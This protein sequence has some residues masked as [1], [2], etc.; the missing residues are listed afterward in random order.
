MFLGFA[1]GIPLGVVMTLF[2]TWMKDSGIDLQTIGL[3]SLVQLPYSCKFLWSPFL[4]RY[5]LPFLGRRKGWMLVAQIGMLISIILLGNFNPKDDIT[6]IMI[7]ATIISFFGATHD[8]VIDA[9]RRDVLSDEEL[10]FG[11]AVATNSYLVG[12]RFLATVLGLTL[13][14]SYSWGFVFTLMAILTALGMI[15][16]MLAPN[17]DKEIAAPKSLKDAVIKPFVNYLMRPGA[18]EILFF[19]LLYKLGDNLAGNLVTPFYLEMGYSKTEIGWVGKMIGFW[20]MFAGGFL[21][22]TLLIKYNIRKC[23]MFFGILQ[24]FSTLLFALLTKTGVSIFALGIVVGFENLTAGMGTAAFAAFM[25]KLCDKK[26]S[27]TQF[28]LL[29]SFMGI[30]RTI[31]PATA[32]FIAEPLG[33]SGFFIVCTLAAIPG[34]LMIQFRSKHWES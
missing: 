18:F 1:S 26:F 27:A 6:I 17:N 3:A 15:G 31:I 25:L 7:M 19:I 34:L 14:D 28:A 24:A 32:G 13:A 30:P 33:W 11:S 23:L 16:T 5:T 21:G 22:G 29:S 10:G 12:F 2:Q 4:D 8:I 9:F 20:A